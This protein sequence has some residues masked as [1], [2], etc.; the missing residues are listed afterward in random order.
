[1]IST[2][3][4]CVDIPVSDPMRCGRMTEKGATVGRPNGVK[5]G[6]RRPGAGWQIH[7][8]WARIRYKVLPMIHR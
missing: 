5:R 7:Q 3:V 8:K 4:K 2:Q 6:T 1:M